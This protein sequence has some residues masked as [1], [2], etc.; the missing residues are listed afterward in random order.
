LSLKLADTR[1]IAAKLPEDERAKAALNDPG[2][3][4]AYRQ[5]QF[6]GREFTFRVTGAARGSVWG[7]EVYTADSTL[8]A[9]AVHMGVL[10]V[11]ETGV[12]TV[13]IMGPLQKFVGSTRNGV[14]TASYN[15][16]PAAYRIHP[17][18]D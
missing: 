14:T 15:Q 16:Y 8:A 9:A 1:S 17:K 6:F 10:K 13:T 3:L 12:V 5:P 2:S 11:G 7:T 4:T 18:E